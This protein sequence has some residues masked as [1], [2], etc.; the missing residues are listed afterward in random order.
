MTT[1][2]NKIACL[3]DNSFGS[4]QYYPYFKS[5][6]GDPEVSLFVFWIG[7]NILL[8]AVTLRAIEMAQLKPVSARMHLRDF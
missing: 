6:P 4:W 7:S 1:V 3:R 2:Y 8:V 5:L